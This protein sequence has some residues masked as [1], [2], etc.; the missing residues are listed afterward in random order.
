[1]AD[2]VPPE[3]PVESI[4]SLLDALQADDDGQ[5][6]WFRGHSDGAWKLLPSLVRRTG[7]VEVEA[8]L[9]KRFKQNAYRFIDFDPRSEWD[10]LFLMQHHGVPTRLLDWTESPLFG[11]WFAVAN[12]SRD[13]TDA[14]I[15]C[16]DPIALNREIA[17]IKLSSDREL[18]A[19][20]DDMELEP[21]LVS[22]L[23]R[24]GELKPVAGIAPRQFERV[25]AQQ[26]VFTI[27]HRDVT[28]LEEMVGPG[29]GDAGHLTK[30]VI[31]AE[32]KPR[33]RTELARLGVNELA[34]FPE[35]PNVAK[36]SMEGL[37]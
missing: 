10:W 31:P 9:M 3:I 1:M 29:I 12:D 11:L 32:S 37:L 18:L 35:L 8:A 16:L 30:L 28:P 6:T 26:G 33:L 13:D 20:A 4:S 22:R 7:G 34:V 23:A 27:H 14:C 17:R 19:F 15:W 5:L 25:Y 24:G 21:Y 2:D 36:V